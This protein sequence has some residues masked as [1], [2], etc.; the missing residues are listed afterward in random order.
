MCLWKK[1]V[2][3]LIFFSFDVFERLNAH[4]RHITKL[5]ETQINLIALV[6]LNFVVLL[7]ILLLFFFKCA[8]SHLLIL[9]IKFQ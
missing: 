1:L 7:L 9:I 6:I 2:K 5:Q 3:F 8:L 4:F